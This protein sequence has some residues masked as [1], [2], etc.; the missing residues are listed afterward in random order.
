MIKKHVHKVIFEK[1]DQKNVLKC[2]IL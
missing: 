2:E 1:Q